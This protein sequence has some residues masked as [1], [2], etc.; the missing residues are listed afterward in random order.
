[1]EKN[2]DETELQ[3]SV[4]KAM[5]GNHSP[6]ASFLSIHLS[7]AFSFYK[8]S[9]MGLSMASIRNGLTASLSHFQKSLLILMTDT[10]NRKGPL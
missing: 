3:R 1:M 6:L 4:P 2:Q 8:G 5:L 7:I 9:T 10:S